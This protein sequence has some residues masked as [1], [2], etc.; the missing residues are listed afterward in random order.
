[1]E[2]LRQGIEEI[3]KNTQYMLPITI[4]HYF[5]HQKIEIVYYGT[6]QL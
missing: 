2:T 3:N 6:S 4:F 1:M 5:G